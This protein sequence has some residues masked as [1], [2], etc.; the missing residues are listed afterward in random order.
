MSDPQPKKRS[1]F[2]P[3]VLAGLAAATLT[4]VATAQPWVSGRSGAFSTGSSAAAQALDEAGVREAPLAAAL[5]LVALACWGVL[6]VTR[7]VVRRAVAVI[8]LFASAGV[9]VVAATSFTP[10]QDELAD[11]LLAASGTD[12]VEITITSWFVAAALGSLIA[13]LAAAAAVRY[14]PAWPEMG[15]RYETPVGAPAT[16]AEDA[17][18]NLDLWKAMDEGHDPTDRGRPLD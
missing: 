16:T 17:D 2:G 3:V 12:T 5:A 15:S 7:G 8:A 9:V 1:S 13:T 11:A 4:A 10:L 14:A 18:G 6:L